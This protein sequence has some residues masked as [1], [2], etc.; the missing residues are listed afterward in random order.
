MPKLPKPEEPN[1]SADTYC[2]GSLVYDTYFCL[3]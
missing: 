3:H 2:W 1:F